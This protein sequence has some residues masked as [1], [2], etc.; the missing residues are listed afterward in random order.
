MDLEECT[1]SQNS[2][3]VVLAIAKGRRLVQGRMVTMMRSKRV[4]VG[5]ERGV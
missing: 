1:V 2:D 3:N 4:E 5:L